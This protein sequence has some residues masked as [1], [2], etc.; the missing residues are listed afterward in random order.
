MEAR[1][2]RCRRARRGDTE[3]ILALVGIA[4]DDRRTRHRFRKLVADL[5]ADCYVALR[6]DAVVGI[7]HVTYARHLLD[8]QCAT[9]E[10]LRVADAQ[11]ADVGEALA[12]LVRERA[13][14]RA[15]ARID[16]RDPPANAPAAALGVEPG[17]AHVAVEIPASRE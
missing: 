17:D 4:D 5:G 8:G 7:V 2:I 13:R 15:C 14:R 3:S 1:P 6:D 11:P 16:W 9:V 10:L 12:T